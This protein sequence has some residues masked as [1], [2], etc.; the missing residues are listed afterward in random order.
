MLFLIMVI[1]H[2]V[3]DGE[4]YALQDRI[5]VYKNKGITG[6]FKMNNLSVR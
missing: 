4:F 6:C 5:T 3:F 2:H 1:I